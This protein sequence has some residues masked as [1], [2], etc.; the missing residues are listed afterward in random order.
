M[1]RWLLVLLALS[2]CAHGKP[3]APVAFAPAPGRCWAGGLAFLVDK[4]GNSVLA[5]QALSYSGA[6]T[7]R[8][9]RPQQIVTT[10]FRADRLNITIDKRHRVKQFTCG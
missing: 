6:R 2:G 8:W 4:Q 5:S 9:I 3:V 1:T 10:E 7:I